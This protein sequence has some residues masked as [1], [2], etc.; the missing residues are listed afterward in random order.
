MIKILEIK[1]KIKN[2]FLSNKYFAIISLK[3]FFWV[4]GKWNG[5]QIHYVQD[6]IDVTKKN[7]KIRIADC[8][9]VYVKDLIA[10]FDYYFN[11]VVS[12]LS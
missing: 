7:K 8:N 11:C 5:I 2:V 9:L 4:T 1:R 12:L 3:L 10:E 6:K